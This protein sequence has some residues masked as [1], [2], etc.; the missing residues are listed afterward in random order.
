MYRYAQIQDNK[1]HW[2][3]EDEMNLSELYIHKFCKDHIEFVDIT[4]RNDIKE[5]WDYLNGVFF[6]PV[7]IQPSI[8]ELLT[9]IRTKRNQLLSE[10]DWTQLPDAPLTVEQKQAWSIYR[11]AL[12]DFPENCDPYNPVWTVKPG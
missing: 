6:A 9:K 10:C 1:V 11:Q 2:I 3:T 12:R 5:G 4:G 7:I 8:D